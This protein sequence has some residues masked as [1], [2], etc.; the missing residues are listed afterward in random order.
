MGG[1]KREMSKRKRRRKRKR[2]RKR[3]FGEAAGGGRRG[4]GRG[5]LTLV[6][7]WLL[8]AIIMFGLDVPTTAATHRRTIVSPR[9]PPS[10]LAHS[11][12]YS[13][14]APTNRAGSSSKASPP[15]LRALCSAESF[16]QPS[17]F[18]SCLVLFVTINP[19]PFACHAFPS[20]PPCPPL[21]HLLESIPLLSS[22]FTS[23]H[24]FPPRLPYLNP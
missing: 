6:A 12:D 5:E 7:C 11:G 2:K 1:G 3:V 16:H 23:A 20:P 4:D 9:R 15:R 10:R 18:G 17:L 24:A 21:P 19:T 14:S 22:L 8:C 13:F